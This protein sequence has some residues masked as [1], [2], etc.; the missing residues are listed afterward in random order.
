MPSIFVASAI[1]GF[2]SFAFTFFTFLRVFWESILTMWNAHHEIR[3]VMDNLRTELYGERA[4]FKNALKQ[5]RSKSKSS[6]RYA[7][8]IQPLAIL[9][10]GIKDLMREFRELE[11]PFLDRPEEA[12]D[13]DIEKSGR[14]SLRG[15]YAPMDLRRR[16]TWLHK[17]D[18]VV[19]LGTMTNRIQ[20]RRIA[21]ET[22]NTLE[23]VSPFPPE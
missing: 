6:T 17:K 23:W 22:S 2:T 21:Y 12:E 7:P 3:P 8:E 4:Y 11:E 16:F 14:V 15:N 18:N 20:S 9:N 10:D 1:V 13:L 5:A 19:N